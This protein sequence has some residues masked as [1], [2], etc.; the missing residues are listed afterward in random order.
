MPEPWSPRH[1]TLRP[2]LE[3]DVPFLLALRLAAMAAHLRAA[4]VELTAAE[5]EQRVRA[6]FDAAHVVE[7]HGER[8]GL[9]KLAR[10]P[11]EW[12]LLQVQLLPRHQRQGIGSHL[13][14]QVLQ[15]ARAQRTA[16]TL[17]VLSVNPAR[18]LYE[19]LGFEV[20]SMSEHG[21]AMRCR[22]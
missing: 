12:R 3:S 8:I 6:D 14:G 19:R 1:L 4:G 7:L 20:E 15:Q 9:L 21:Y 13:I 22:A 11:G 10:A 16:V 18:R 2:A 5:T 17:S